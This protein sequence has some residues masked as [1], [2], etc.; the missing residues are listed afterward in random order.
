MRL[1]LRR[2]NGVVEVSPA[3]ANVVE[4]ISCVGQS[5]V[6]PAGCPADVCLGWTLPETALVAPSSASNMFETPPATQ[7]L[8]GR[9]TLKISRGLTPS[10]ASRTA[11]L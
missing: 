7:E 8:I 11:N 1:L 3:D 4:V 9:Y 5:S 2:S 6:W 10:I